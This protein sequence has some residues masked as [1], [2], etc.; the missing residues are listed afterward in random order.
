MK[1]WQSEMIGRT[2]KSRLQNSK[3]NVISGLFRQIV[4]IILTFA[5]RTVILYTLG[6]QYQGLSGLF[7]SIL[8]TLN[9]TELGISSAVTFVLYKP[10]AEDDKESIC[11]ILAF[12]KKA[13]RVIGLLILAGGMV[14]MP[15]L[16]LLIKGDYPQEI[17][18][19]VLYGIYIANAVASYMIYAD[20]SI[21]LT[22][23]QRVDLVS[24][25]YTVTNLI[26]KIFQ[27]LILIVFRNYYVYVFMILIVGITNNAL[28][29]LFSR[30]IYPD[31]KAVGIIDAEIKNELI[32]HVKAIFINKFGD[33][34][35]NSFDNVVISAFVGLTAVA[36]YD[37]YYLIFVSLYGIMGIIVH[38]VRASIGN[39]IV[40]ESVEKNYNDL[41]SFS[42]IFMWIVGWIATCMYVLYQPFMIIWMNGNDSLLLCYGDMILF[43]V[44]FYVLSMSY[45]KNVYL[46]ADGLFCESR[47]LYIGEAI[48]NLI[49]N[50]V[51]GIF[52][53]ITGVLV[54]T[55]ITIIVFNFLGG[56]MILFKY[57]FR[58][59]AWG[60]LAFH[61]LFFG[62][63]MI[64][65]VV[66]KLLTDLIP[67]CGVLGLLIKL[68]VCVAIPNI[69]FW[70]VFHLLPEYKD[71]KKI[72]IGLVKK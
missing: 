55:I 60:F 36:I 7:T 34:C 38:S 4:T 5:I 51:L 8:H 26:G 14:T 43:C 9:L 24:N 58:R 44:Y 28:T 56:T 15:F 70:T 59:S 18:I 46:E 71:V 39:S 22:A 52:W 47:L 57:Y 63:T 40:K 67:V 10:I 23:M 27:I 12:L 30:R 41:M 21:Y 65:G 54:A 68:L 69:L 45:T 72:L 50:L 33:V 29:E 31:I 13:Y 64:A 35:R 61:C 25:A 11:S 32:S 42:Y 17:N 6:T 3:R 49:L 66:T 1:D 48:G 62:I 19:Y 37:N 16:R 2:Y 53:G 20:K